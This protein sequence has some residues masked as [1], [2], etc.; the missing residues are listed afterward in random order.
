MRLSLVTE[1]RFHRTPDG[2]IWTSTANAYPFWT[3]YLSVFDEANVTAR[4]LDV[5]H[6]D[7]L[8]TRADGPAVRFSAVPYYVGPYQFAWHWPGIRRALSSAIRNDDAVVMRVPSFLA[9][10]LEPALCKRR[11]PY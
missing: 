11:Q 7:D 5:P 8:W 3:R 4:V 2:S 6:T 9:N 10:C 1:Q